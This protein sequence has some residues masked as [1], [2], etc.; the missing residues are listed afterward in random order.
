MDKHKPYQPGYNFS[1]IERYLKGELSPA[2]MHALEKAALSDPFL[3]D[4]LEGY[5]TQALIQSQTDLT[6][7]HNLIAGNKEEEAKVIALPRKPIRWQMIAAVFILV[8]GSG[9][10]FLLNQ[11]SDQ[12]N[13]V[14][15]N[16]VQN[17][18][19]PLATDTTIRSETLE[20]IASA[21]PVI[22]SSKKKLDKNNDPVASAPPN[23]DIAM[24]SSEQADSLLKL[25][26]ATAALME[27]KK[28]EA[29]RK[30]SMQ[31][32]S[33]RGMSAPAPQNYSAKIS[34]PVTASL[35]PNRQLMSRENTYLIKGQVIDQRLQ[36][37]VNTQLIINN[38][39][40]NKVVF[41]DKQGYFSISSPDSINSLQIDITGY[42][43]L[44]TKLVAGTSNSIQLMP[45]SSN[46]ELKEVVVNSVAPKRVTQMTG[47]VTQV[48]KLMLQQSD[49]V[50]KLT[51]S[52]G[53]KAM[54][55]KIQEELLR[56]SNLKDWPLEDIIVQLSFNRN[57]KLLEIEFPEGTNKEVIDL[58]KPVLK[59]VENWYVGKNKATGKWTFTLPIKGK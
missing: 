30:S 54:Q 2:E 17:K 43:K 57:G 18:V 15:I 1:D 34:T 29:L 35:D 39:T 37:V 33:Q 50:P 47:S 45:D 21:T 24:A 59:S 58:I 10:I 36:P 41:T 56:S 14:A 53:M 55:A 32:M 7:I 16:K 8:C 44:K 27:N 48:N 25:Q 9:I 13:T 31:A 51:P 3:A 11:T 26:Q 4:A 12:T 19:T 42:A 49:S 28:M 20:P 40:T 6:T 52:M 46:G 5:G 22:P 23:S 38:A